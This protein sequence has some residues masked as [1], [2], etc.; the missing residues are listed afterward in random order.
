MTND[1]KTR[2]VLL[3]LPSELY[4]GL[5]RQSANATLQRSERITLQTVIREA[6]AEFLERQETLG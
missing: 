5:L 6:I 1:T 3:R 2:Q 4:D